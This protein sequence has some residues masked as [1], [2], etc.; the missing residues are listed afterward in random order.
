MYM[1]LLPCQMSKEFTTPKSTAMYVL[2]CVSKSY[3]TSVM[4]RPT[5]QIRWTCKKVL[6]DNHKYVYLRRKH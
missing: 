6:V 3:A 1:S 4:F 2:S 5:T